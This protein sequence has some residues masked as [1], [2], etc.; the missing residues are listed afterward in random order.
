[1]RRYRRVDRARPAGRAP[2][3]PHGLSRFWRG[4]RP[5]PRF[6]LIA[7]VIL[8][9]ILAEGGVWGFFALRPQPPAT[10]MTNE[11][12]SRKG[13]HTRLNDDANIFVAVDG[14][15]VLP[16]QPVPVMVGDPFEV[17]FHFAGMLGDPSRFSRVGM[18]ILVPAQEPVWEVTYGTGSHPATWSP[19]YVGSAHWSPTWDR[20]ANGDGP[21][22]AEWVRSPDR[23]NAYYLSWSREAAAT[24]TGL[25]LVMANTT[26]DLGP[27][28]QADRDGLANHAGADA[29]IIVSEGTAPGVY[30]VEVSGIGHTEDGRMAKVSTTIA[31]T[32]TAPLGRNGA[33]AGR[34][35][36]GRDLYGQYCKGCHGATPNTALRR[37]LNKGEAEIAASVR[38]GKGKMEAFGATAGGPL[39]EEQ[40]Q[41]V[42]R[43][44]LNEAE[45]GS[46]SGSP[47]I[48]HS[49]EGR[50]DCWACHRQ[51]AM[52]PTPSGHEGYTLERCT[53]CHRQGPAWMTGPPIVHSLDVGTDCLRCHSR[54]GSIGVPD[55]HDGRTDPTC[56]VCHTPG[57]AI[58]PIPHAVQQDFLCLTC[59]GQ[60]GID[61]V[62]AS[63]EGRG[64]EVCRDCHRPASALL[65]Q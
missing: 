50:S 23:A 55:T 30:H 9:L 5:L 14:R 27:L 33:P 3:A 15:E 52:L 18:E 54:W 6:W 7:A 10:V 32:V 38:D 29:L 60:G 40:L 36:S 4:R 37:K 20:A 22:L 61:P 65:R 28:D 41:A 17:D 53:G 63:H 1:M 46:R 57:A 13:C 16:N 39:S 58:P 35:P 49:L 21:T 11:S 43:Y 8:A 19:E 42:V 31:V 64:E 12:C 2:P 56:L 47:A 34:P 45:L 62:P 44:L 25:D 26:S 51:G 24:A 48:P 59:H